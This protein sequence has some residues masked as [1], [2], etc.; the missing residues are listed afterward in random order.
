MEFFKI[1]IAALSSSSDGNIG[2]AA[3]LMSLM[4]KNIS[5]REVRIRHISVKSHSPEHDGE[6]KTPSL[7]QKSSFSL[8]ACEYHL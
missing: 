1:F 2:N 3:F 8:E 4:Y 6:D 7:T 5:Q